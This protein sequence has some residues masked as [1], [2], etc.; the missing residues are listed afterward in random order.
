MNKIKKIIEF[1]LCLYIFILPWQTILIFKENFIVDYKNQFGTL[2][3]YF[4]EI[5]LWLLIIFVIIFFIK[6]IKTE[7]KINFFWSLDRKFIFS[8]F[9]FL[10]YS[11]LSII[12]SFDKELAWQKSLQIL[13]MFLFFLILL[14][15]FVDYKKILKVLVWSSIFPGVLGIYGFLTQSFFANKFLGLSFYDASF[16]GP[17]IIAGDTIG[18][19]L[20]NYGSFPHPNFFAGFLLVSFL[21]S[22]LL[23]KIEKNKIFIFLIMCL[24]LMSLFFTFSRSA[25]LSL[26]FL[27]MFLLYFFRKDFKIFFRENKIYFLACFCLVGFLFLIFKPLIFTRLAG[28][29]LAEQRSYSERSELNFESIEIIKNNFLFGIGAGNYIFAVLKNNPE[30]MPF[31]YQPVHNIFLLFF[32]E[33]GLFG[34]VFFIS[35]LYFFSKFYLNFS[36]KKYNYVLIIFC[37]FLPIFLL[38]HYFYSF[39]SGMA[40]FSLICFIFFGLSSDNPLFFPRKAKNG[41]N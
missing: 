10:S 35:M 22:C 36:E 16:S 20:R 18:R 29:T 32:A 31:A 4:S 24:Q 8:G 40:Y 15:N 38:D 34:T 30:K 13:E 23:F 7:G 1:L 21:A 41:L 33:F 12:W 5:I 26:F 27:L 2:G 14:L 9:L 25:F 37:L 28:Q 6:K 39:Y 3:L 11:F 19:W 17:S